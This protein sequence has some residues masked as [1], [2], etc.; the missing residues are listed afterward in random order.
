MR[1]GNNMFS[2]LKRKLVHFNLEEETVRLL[3]GFASQR[4][5]ILSLNSNGEFKGD[6]ENT[7]EVIA[8]MEQNAIETAESRPLDIYWY[9][10]DGQRITPFFSS[11]A[12]VGAFIESDPAHKWKAFTTAG[13]V[14]VT[15]FKYLMQAASTGSKVVLD[16][17]SDSERLISL[18]ALEALVGKT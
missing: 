10:Q 14:G 18:S 7:E 12:T 11:S 6:P 13:L 5:F 2:F 8:W 15:L 16:P 17:R 9:E 4:L 1:T 3:K